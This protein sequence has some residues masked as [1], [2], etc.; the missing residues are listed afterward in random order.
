MSKFYRNKKG[1]F[2]GLLVL[3]IQVKGLHQV[4]VF[5]F[6]L[7]LLFLWAVRKLLRAS[8]SVNVCAR[9]HVY[10]CV[11]TSLILFLFLSTEQVPE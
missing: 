10:V 1:S 6:G 7:V 2:L 3:G 11:Y 5:F 8:P 4:M 9:V